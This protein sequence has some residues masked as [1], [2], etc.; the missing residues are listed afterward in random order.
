MS[1]ACFSSHNPVGHDCKTTPRGH[2]QIP[3]GG[4]FV[5]LGDFQRDFKVTYFKYGAKVA[6]LIRYDGTT[7]EV[8][9]SCTCPDFEHRD[10]ANTRTCCKHI[11]ACIDKE[12]GTTR[13]GGNYQLFLVE[14][15]Q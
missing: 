14:H 13:S 7:E 8:V 11:Q 3:T 2:F 4:P 10:R 9:W 5:Y 12:M 6:Y 15:V 1:N